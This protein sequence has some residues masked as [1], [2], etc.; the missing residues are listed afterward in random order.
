MIIESDRD[1]VCMGDDMSRH[2]KFSEFP[3]KTKMSELIEELVKIHSISKGWAIWAG[4]Y[5]TYK[6]ITDSDGNWLIDKNTTLKTF[7]KDT[8]K[9]VFFDKESFE[10]KCKKETTSNGI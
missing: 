7:F 2:N 10:K 1:S 5:D 4:S 3:D 6:C 8:K 9:Y